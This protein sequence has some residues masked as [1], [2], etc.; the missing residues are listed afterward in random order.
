MA[1][2][3]SWFKPPS[4]NASVPEISP[5]E[6]SESNT[7]SSGEKQDVKSRE[8]DVS[9]ATQDLM[10]VKIA[11]QWDPNLPPEKIEAIDKALKDGDTEE[12]LAADALFSEDSPYEEVRAA[13]RNTDGEEVANTVRAWI[14]GMVFVTIG[15]ALNMFLSM[16]NPQINF[17]AIVV[18][19][20]VYP[21][22]CLWAK[23]VPTRVFNTFGMQWTFN[24]GPFTIKEH[25]VIT[26]MSNVS[27]GYAYS[28]DAL[29]ALKGKPFYNLDM[30]WGF[31][32][33][34]TLSSQLIGIGLAGLC[35]R[36]LVWP[37]AMIWPNQFANTSLFH[38]LHDRR[39]SDGS[40]SNGWVIS[41]YRYF[42]YVL[43]AM[44]CYYWIPAVLWQ[45]L[46]VFAFVTWIRPDNVVLNQLFGGFTGLS[47]I[48]I[49]FD[50]TYVTAYLMDPLLSPTH[51]HV[52]VLVG[53]FMFVIIP[54]IGMAYTGSL[55]ADYL[56]IN[57]SQTYDNAQGAYNVT[58]ILGDNL[59]FDVDKY[60]QYSPIFL[61][62][63]FA[64]NY[65]LSFAALI[66]VLVHVALF[67]GREIWYR[68]RTARDQ[69]PD[70][71]MKLMKKYVDAPE[72]W[73]GALLVIALGLGL[74]TAEGY[75]S[76]LPWWAFL[77]ANLLAIVFVVP[78][79]TILAVS[80][81]ALALNVLSPYLA[82]FIIPGRPI[83]VM[84]FKVYSTI[85]LGQAQTYSGDLKMA[86]YMKIPPR[87][88]FWCQV[89]A[90]VWA[91]FVQIAVMNWTLGT[92][93]NCCDL[94]Q[95][96]HFSCPNGRTFFSSSIVWGAI[97]P[98]RMFG[99]GSIY[100]RFNYFWLVGA[101]LPAALYALSS[102]SSRLPASFRGAA[103][104]LHAPVMLGAMNW[105]PPATPLSFSTWAVAGLAFNRGIRRRWPGWW[106]TYNYITA[107]ALDA[108]LVIGT[109]VVF[110]A[111]TLPDVRIPQWWGNVGV[112]ETA[113]AAYTAILKL[114][115]EGE[116]FGPATW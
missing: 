42:F 37:S 38:A 103:A 55:F 59:R 82:G 77:V 25:V 10:K 48:P 64:L 94:K 6:P 80:N 19:L 96:A 72:W 32:L 26:L 52:N 85:T 95:P 47:L 30:G 31:Q 35:R 61:A 50:W 39:K 22:G 41:R 113:D 89:I 12:I 105:L 23:I 60:K 91:S 20:L 81:I 92:I 57:T 86:H 5:I 45:G 111:V 1:M 8:V 75:D 107:A 74:A 70:I 27:I 49:T 14:L 97:G 24:T 54:T 53:V 88:T 68:F 4:D 46:S 51:T 40:Q 3:R 34:F 76:Q 71:H 15:S 29:V 108:G 58:K 78:T 90:T 13:V 102:P 69:E 7:S 17:P 112:Y 116:T 84:I 9:Q 65:G 44:F 11:H 2:R 114:V 110:F 16:R 83:G 56:P 87:I 43:I 79:C 62:P 66:A 63:T 115:G 106:R 98:Q 100:A 109:I 101:L 18:Q 73:Y 33:L 36:F 99:P 28:T 93:E 21:I 104:G 67:H